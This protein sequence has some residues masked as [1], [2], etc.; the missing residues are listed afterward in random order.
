MTISALMAVYN[1]ED[2]VQ[3]AIESIASQL[4]NEDELIISNDESTD[5][6]LLICKEM[7]KKYP[8]I[9]IIEHKRTNV[10]DHMFFLI[11][12]ATKDVSVI[13]DSDDISEPNRISEIKKVY[14]AHPEIKCVY[15]NARII[16]ERNEITSD[17][18]FDSFAQID[19][20]FHMFLKS[21][22]FGA[23]MTF[24]TAF[25][26]KIIE[27]RPKRGLSWDKVI[28]FGMKRNKV[29]LFEKNLKLLKYRRWSDN[30]SVKK[31]PIYDKIKEKIIT[32]F[33]YIKVKIK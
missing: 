30:I 2:T 5:N 33:F 28:G 17:D 19:N 15:H 6:T 1:R 10:D 21:T 27:K 32:F 29:I 31:R 3:E 18:F 4:S 11:D 12:K 7:Q 23:C 14:Q 16:N 20:L 24:N 9:K 8:F 13:C 22:F 25:A 26:K